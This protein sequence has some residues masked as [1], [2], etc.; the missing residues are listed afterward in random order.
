MREFFDLLQQT[1][2]EIPAAEP[3]VLLALLILCL[4]LRATRSGLLIAYIFVYR[5]GW[6]WFAHT[7]RQHMP[8]YFQV[9][10]YLGIAVFILSAF[11]M[12]NTPQP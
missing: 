10:C 9:Y 12:W 8:L 4:V 6:I 1:Q 5:W 7:F 2:L 3:L 11:R